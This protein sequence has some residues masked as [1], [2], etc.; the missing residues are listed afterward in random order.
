MKLLFGL[1]VA[2]LAVVALA[3]QRDTFTPKPLGWTSVANLGM[4]SMTIAAKKDLLVHLDTRVPDDSP[5]TKRG[6][7]YTEAMIVRRRNAEGAYEPVAQFFDAT[8]PTA[9]TNGK[10]IA[11]VGE[12]VVLFT[13]DQNNTLSEASY[14][15]VSGGYLLSDDSFVGCDRFEDGQYVIRT[16]Q[17]EASNNTWLNVPGTELNISAQVYAEGDIASFRVSDTHLVLVDES[18]NASTVHIYA[19]QADL[20]WNLTESVS[21]NNTLGFRSVNYNGV[22]TVVITLI[23][24]INAGVTNIGIVFT[25]TK[26]NGNWIE[27]TI[28][29]D[30]LGYR[31]ISI[32]GA[33]VL[34]VDANT[35]LLSAGLEG[36]TSDALSQSGGKVL[37]LTR[38]EQGTWVPS[39]DVVANSG[40]FGLGVGMND[41]DIIFGAAL[42][43]QVGNPSISFY[44]AP[45]C[46]AQPINITCH[47]QQANDCSQAFDPQ[48]L[49][50][51][52]NAQCGNVEATLSGISLV[53]NAVQT[54]F[55]FSKGFGPAVQCSAKVTCPA[56]PNAQSP[57][58]NI[59][60]AGIVQLGI[61]SFVTAVLMLV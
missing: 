46:F 27:Q 52:N 6:I 9:S 18:D 42:G 44:T 5:V 21:I 54:Q 32:F 15:E 13:I 25:Y 55:S 19:R 29:P 1:I 8:S 60:S 49:Y 23:Q 12:G 7:S 20:S 45:R 26:V 59:S 35:L 50:T 2:V 3:Q 30:A 38:N 39:L 33:S 4:F 31:P 57:S 40:I 48:S 51:V 28:S 34:F 61:A 53:N 11:V 24:S 10:W 58:N 41:Y 17:H 43:V 14:V 47:D 37:L 22:D 36:I 16:Y 56:S